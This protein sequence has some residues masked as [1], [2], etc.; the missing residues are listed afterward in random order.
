[1]Q[2]AVFL[3]IT[4][5]VSEGPVVIVS[6]EIAEGCLEVMAEIETDEKRRVITAKG[7]HLHGAGFDA[8]GLGPIRLRQIARAMLEELDYDE[9][10]IEGGVRT[11]G[12]NPG[13]RPKPVRFTRKPRPTS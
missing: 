9:C 6:I 11:T 1:M 8:N 3:S 10:R 5:D 7:L 13:R 2:D 12:A 4:I